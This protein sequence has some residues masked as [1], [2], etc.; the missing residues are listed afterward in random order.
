MTVHILPKN[1]KVINTP[2]EHADAI[3]LISKLMD[4]GED[5]LP[6]RTKLRRRTINYLIGDLSESIMDYERRTVEQ[7]KPTKAEAEE[8][9]RDQERR[10]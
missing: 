5:W 8:F 9:R 2:E 4:Y 10:G 6:E 7:C 3:K 1:Q